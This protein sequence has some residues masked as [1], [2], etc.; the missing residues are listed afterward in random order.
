MQ[1]L[2]KNRLYLKMHNC[3][4]L[5][6]NNNCAQLFVAVIT[7]F[8]YCLLLLFVLKLM[9]LIEDESAQKVIYKL[10]EMG[11]R[12]IRETTGLFDTGQHAEL[13]TAAG[14]QAAVGTRRR[15]RAQPQHQDGTAAGGG[16]AGG[17]L[18]QDPAGAGLQNQSGVIRTNCLDCLDRTT[19]AQFC[20]E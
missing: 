13:A 2:F 7:L 12:M 5:I 11:S 19:V 18:R 20:G 17:C 1:A 4:C 8:L 6:Q 14:V 9:D 3:C 15:P 10:G 16:G